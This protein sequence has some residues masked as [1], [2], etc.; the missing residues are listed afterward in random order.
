M[1]GFAP[2]RFTGRRE[3]RKMIDLFFL[4]FPPSCSNPATT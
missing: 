4:D 3:D 1:A 2:E